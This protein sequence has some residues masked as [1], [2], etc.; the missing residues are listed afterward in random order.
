MGEP[1]NLRGAARAFEALAALIVAH[2][3]LRPMSAIKPV[4]C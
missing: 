4:A 2:L 3:Y 1:L